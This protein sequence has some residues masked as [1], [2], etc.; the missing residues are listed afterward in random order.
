MIRSKELGN[1][2]AGMDYE[3][4]TCGCIRLDKDFLWH[5]GLGDATAEDKMTIVDALREARTSDG[6]AYHVFVNEE[7]GEPV[8]YVSRGRL[9]KG[10][11]NCLPCEHVEECSKEKSARNN[12]YGMH[13]KHCTYEICMLDVPGVRQLF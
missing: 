1:L 8:Y 9:G 6:R 5:F 12:W 11:F 2:I 7:C 13:C 3:T 10:S 4:V